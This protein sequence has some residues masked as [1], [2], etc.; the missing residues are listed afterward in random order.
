MQAKELK[1]KYVEFFKNKGHAI[2]PSA[3]LIPENDPTVLFTTAGMHPLVPFLTGQ[4]HPSGKKVT[5]YQ[6]CIRTGDIDEVGDTTHHTF[7]EMLGNWSFGDYFKKEAIEWSFEFLTKELRL[8]IEKLAVTCFKGDKNAPK[9]EESATIWKNLGISRITFLGKNDNWWGPAGETG[10]CG[11][12]TEM[13]YWVGKGK[14]TK[15]DP[16]DEN[17]VEIW[18]DVFMQYDKQKDGS[19]KP[20]KQQSV[21][22]GLGVE[23]VITILQGLDDNYLTKQFYPIIEK[24]EEITGKKYKTNKR[25]MRIIADHIRAAVFILGDERSVV[26]SNLDQGYILRRF[27]R[28]TIRHL[29]SLGVDIIK[30]DY[31]VILAKLV[32]KMY[33]GEYPEFEGKKKFILQELQN[34]E[35]KFEKTLEK[36]LREFEKMSD[37]NIITG[38]DA[39]LLFQSYGFPLEMTAELAIEKDVKLDEEAF[40]EEY[41]KHQ[42]LSRV[43]AEK[44]FKGGLSDASEETTRLHTTTHLL[45]EALRIVVS[46]DIKQRGSNITPERLRFDFSFERKL[47]DE[48]KQAVEDEVNRV[49]DAGMDVTRK[50][51]PVPEAEKLGAE[52]EFGAK[53]PDIVSV[54]F[55]GDYSKEFCGGPHVKNTSELG[56]FKIVKEQSSSAGVRRIKAI[57]E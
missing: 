24:V 49:I 40:H 20:L 7:F 27:I 14:P 48:E 23:R 12:D 26:P 46:K 13:F 3:S 2:I 39:F 34:E 32:I 4:K 10:P 29:R 11:P 45:N 1:K 37:D 17:W 56:H 9:D 47:T 50:E 53:Y 22:T 57:L 21:D 18:N 6:K 44:K 28:R 41:K 31:T 8:P 19:F 25:A 42:E 30:D 35:R 43:G 33:K 15:F 55:V 51:M 16:D 52:K 38:K 5:N 36:G 54:Y